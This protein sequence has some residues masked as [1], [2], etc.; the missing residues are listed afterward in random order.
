MPINIYRV[1]P[2]GQGDE[3]V[4]WLCDDDWLLWREIEA[5]SLW[6]EESGA[7]LPPAEYVADVGFC[8]RRSASAGGPVLKSSMLRRMADLGMHLYLSEYS[9][10]APNDP[11]CPDETSE[12]NAV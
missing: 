6:L 7:S 4:A 10:F 11:L 9:G 8:W 2:D 12:Q 5:L 3:E 1:T